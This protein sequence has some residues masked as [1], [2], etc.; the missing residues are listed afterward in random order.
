MDNKNFEGE[1]ADEDAWWWRSG[2]E[3][4]DLL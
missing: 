4:V 1:L 2:D 3:K